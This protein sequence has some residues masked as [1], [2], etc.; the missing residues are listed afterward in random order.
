MDADNALSQKR[1]GSEERDRFVGYAGGLET[2]ARIRE[3]AFNH[4]FM[5]FLVRHGMEGQVYTT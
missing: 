4:C 5:T 2:E 3:H 1:L